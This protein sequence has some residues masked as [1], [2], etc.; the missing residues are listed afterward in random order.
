MAQVIQLDVENMASAI[1]FDPA[2]VL[3]GRVHGQP[4]R[5]LQS[6]LMSITSGA[7][8]CRV[9]SY[10][11]TGNCITDDP[12]S[13]STALSE[14]LDVAITVVTTPTIE[15]VRLDRRDIKSL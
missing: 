14:S 9:S 5:R 4:G 8:H 7:A 13:N 10:G 12:V 6:D 1:Y 11:G 3:G 2:R 15:S